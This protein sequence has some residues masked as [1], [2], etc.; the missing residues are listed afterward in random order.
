MFARAHKFQRGQHSEMYLLT[1][2]VQGKTK[3]G[4]PLDMVSKHAFWYLYLPD[5]EAY[6]YF[7]KHVTII[8]SYPKLCFQNISR[9]PLSSAEVIYIY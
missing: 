7:Q 1:L 3:I 4:L 2:K 5:Y 8:P 6:Y 9:K